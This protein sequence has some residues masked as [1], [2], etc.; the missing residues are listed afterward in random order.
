MSGN[1]DK[2]QQSDPINEYLRLYLENEFKNVH[3]SLNRIEEHSKKNEESI[4]GVIRTINRMQ[5]IAP[6]HYTECPNT[7]EIQKVTLTLSEFLFFKKYYRVFLTF[8][9]AV[10]LGMGLSGIK[11]W[12]EFTNLR[13]ERQKI[14]V[15]LQS[16][17]SPGKGGNY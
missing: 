14:K 10:S 8:A 6:T 9:L 2:S 16:K 13:M 12:Q 7:L 15:E 3:I 5:L 11:L 1:K 4:Q 17:Q